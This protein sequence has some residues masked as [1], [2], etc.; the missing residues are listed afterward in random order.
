MQK[1]L[2]TSLLLAGVVFIFGYETGS[3]MEKEEICPINKNHRVVKWKPGYCEIRTVN[4]DSSV[5]YSNSIRCTG[6]EQ[7]H[8]NYNQERIKKGF[9]PVKWE[10]S[11]EEPRYVRETSNSD[12]SSVKYE[13]YGSGG[14]SGKFYYSERNGKTHATWY[15]PDDN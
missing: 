15:Q 13:N 7:M 4:C 5:V 14:N 8:E 11:H 3:A 1:F 12:S 10:P 2:Q 9:Y 6:R